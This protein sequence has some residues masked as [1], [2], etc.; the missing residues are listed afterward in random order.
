MGPRYSKLHWRISV[1]QYSMII[2]G[3]K[4]DN[5]QMKIFDIF[6]IYAQNI[7]CGNTLE[8]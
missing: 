2:H 8:Q 5:F 1:M 7:D 4:K 6:L 3:Y